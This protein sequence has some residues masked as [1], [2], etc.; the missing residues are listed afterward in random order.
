MNNVGDL[1]RLIVPIN[2]GLRDTVI[3]FDSGISNDP[4]ACDRERN[5]T[6]EKYEKMQ[7]QLFEAVKELKALKF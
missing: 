2:M 4:R 3:N 6:I 1:Q 5:L 7:Q